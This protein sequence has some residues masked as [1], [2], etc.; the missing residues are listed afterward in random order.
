[1]FK[2]LLTEYERNAIRPR[3]LGTFRDMLEATAKSP[4]MLFYLDNWMS[5]DPNGPHTELGPPRIVRG[6]FGRTIVLPP[7][8]PRRLVLETAERDVLRFHV[9][10]RYAADAF[11][12]VSVPPSLI[13]H[14]FNVPGWR[15]KG[16]FFAALQP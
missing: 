4:A 9:S 16:K 10:L 6:R 14:H 5:V 15:H 11:A 2:H 13:E 7:Q 12:G 8:P 3:V 1:M